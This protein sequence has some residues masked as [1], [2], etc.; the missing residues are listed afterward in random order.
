MPG[1]LNTSKERSKHQTSMKECS[2]Y[3]TTKQDFAKFAR[4]VRK[5]GAVFG[6]KDWE[7]SICHEQWTDN[8]YANN[9]TNYTAR[10]ASV[11]LSREWPAKPRKGEIERSAFH[12]VY[13]ILLAP[14]RACA[15]ARFVTADE[16]DEAT[17]YVVRT[18]ESIM[19][20]DGIR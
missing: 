2:Q 19:L 11:N 15:G 17:H 4:C 6:L 13:E 16:I 14:L 18:M 20:K 10:A 3:K 1:V 7:I 8:T 12:E 5:W 9:S